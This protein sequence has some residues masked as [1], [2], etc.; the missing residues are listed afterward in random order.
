MTVQP[1]LIVWTIICFLALFFILRGLLFRPLLSLMDARE[2]KIAD[3]K[4]AGEEARLRE[5][6][7]ARFL[8]S[9]N[10]QTVKIKSAD[11]EKKADEIR[12][13][14]KKQLEEA[15]NRRFAE[16]GAYRAE[17]DEAFAAEMKSTEEFSDRA[18]A[19]FL[20]RLFEN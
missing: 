9:E 12:L 14:G 10:E 5:E 1:S 18:A 7:A 8:A 11:S 16:I 2:K 15:K 20:G 4:R 6:E 13:E 3:A 17:T 19:L